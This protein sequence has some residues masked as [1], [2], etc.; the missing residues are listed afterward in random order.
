MATATA[1]AT[2]RVGS[3]ARA[4]VMVRRWARLRLTAGVRARGLAAL[5]LEAGNLQ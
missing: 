4:T 5:A 3:R 2:G 1:T